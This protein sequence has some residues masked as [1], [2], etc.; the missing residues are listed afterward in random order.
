MLTGR[1]RGKTRLAKW[2]APYS[3]GHRDAQNRAKANSYRMKRRSSSKAR[4]ISL[5]S[6]FHRRH[7]LR[8]P[9]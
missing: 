1:H 3:V 2:Y 7:P 5:P 9:S 6:S 8:P 4:Y